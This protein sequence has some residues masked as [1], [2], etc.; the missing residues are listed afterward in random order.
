MTLP[1]RYTVRATCSDCSFTG[2]LAELE[3]HLCHLEETRASNG[4]R[5][6]DFPC[7]GHVDGDG[8]SPRQEH[9]SDYWLEVLA[10][11]DG[12]HDSEDC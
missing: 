12:R 11:A 10:M 2:T 8:C 3:M 1:A 9:T 6:E 5:C 7:C 4:G